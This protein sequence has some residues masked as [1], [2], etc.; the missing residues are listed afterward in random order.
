MRYLTTFIQGIT[1]F[2]E[3][4]GRWF[5]SY[6]AF[7]IF[8][9]LLFEMVARYVFSSPTIWATELTQMMFGAYVMLS[10]GYLLVHRGHLNVDIFYDRFKPRTRAMVDIVT[11]LLFFA[12]LLVLLKEGW[13]MAED[14][15]G[16]WERSH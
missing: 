5:I 15:M 2:N 12:F 10:G 16:R 14:A 11:S 3:R 8:A 1:W 13:Q 6:L 9:L 7:V 4:L